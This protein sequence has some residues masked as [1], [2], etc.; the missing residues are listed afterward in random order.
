MKNLED[1]NEP[2]LREFF[3]D[4]ARKLEADLPAGPSKK[5]KCLFFLIVTDRIEAGVGQ[6][7]SNVRRSDA[8]KMLRET[9][10]RLEKKEDV[11]R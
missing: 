1:M 10:D 9:A 5:G 4:L 11:T 2:E 6:Y 8:I 7:V 3:S